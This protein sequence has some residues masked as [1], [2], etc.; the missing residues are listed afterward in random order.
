MFAKFEI[1]RLDLPVARKILG[2]AIG[3]CPKEA[4]FRGYIEL[5]VEVCIDKSLFRFGTVLR[6]DLSSCETSITS[7]N[8]IKNISRYVLLDSAKSHVKLQHSLFSTV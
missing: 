3:M 4:L 6:F 2:A 8:C 7:E 1:R 5:E